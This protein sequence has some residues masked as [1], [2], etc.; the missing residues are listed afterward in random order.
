MPLYRRCGHGRLGCHLLRSL[1]CGYLLFVVCLPRVAALWGRLPDG[2]T[3]CTY[4][5]RRR[6]QNHL[7]TGQRTQ[8]LSKLLLEPERRTIGPLIESG[9][10]CWLSFE[11]GHVGFDVRDFVLCSAQMV[12]ARVGYEHWWR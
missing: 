12:P 6:W 3:V 7:L 10:V 5:D 4:C 9:L 11:L 8:F 2:L 1:R